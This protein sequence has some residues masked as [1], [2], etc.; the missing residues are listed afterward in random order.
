MSNLRSNF[1]LT[2]SNLV[3]W[4][5]VYGWLHLLVGV[6]ASMFA[7]RMDSRLHLHLRHSL[8]F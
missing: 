4:Y 6:N 8:V 7:S 3:D 1:T 5:I 2:L